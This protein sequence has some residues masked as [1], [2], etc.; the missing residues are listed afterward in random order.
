[1]SGKSTDLALV[2]SGGGARAA[3][4]VGF[5]QYI[6]HQYPEFRPSII[7]GVSAGAINAVYLASHTGGFREKIDDLAQLWATLTTDQIFRVDVY[8]IAKNVTRWGVRVL[9]GRASSAIHVRSLLDARPLRAF[10]D[11]VLGMVDGRLP[12]IE[13]NLN[14][15]AIKAIAVTGSSYYTGQSVTWVQGR[16]IKGWER[17][18]RK[19]VLCRLDV[20]HVLASASLP[21]FFSAEFVDDDWY[22]DGG[23]LL[24][25]PLAP[26]V[27][28]GADRIL[29]IATRADD[30]DP[31]GS[32]LLYPPPAQVAG[33]LYNAIFLDAF[34][35]D[36]M[37]L[38]R[39]NQLIRDLPKDKRGELRNVDLLLFRPSHDLGSIANRFEPALPPAFRFMTRGLGTH[40][41]SHN[42]LLS[43]LMFQPDYLKALLD[44][45]YA[46]AQARAEEIAK[47]LSA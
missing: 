11:R 25:S 24:T 17:Q 44:Q 5:L 3:Y 18:D 16:E 21:F 32:A 20:R 1:M 43:I 28:L 38:Q 12:G 19:S 14:S 23:I 40:E 29:V 15:G 42:D 8:T 13:E 45:G 30:Y 35:A 46:D 34:D 41:A 4:Q 39:I 6:A 47:L 31:R 10:L 9:S 37:R 36:V 7:T 22:G 33:A 2:M 27:H 26:A